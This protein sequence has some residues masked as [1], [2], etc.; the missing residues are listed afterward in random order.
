M[1][2]HKLVQQKAPDKQ[3][4]IIRIIVVEVVLNLRF[5]NFISMS[6]QQKAPQ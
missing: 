4:P 6:G 5:N 1:P 3:G 2:S